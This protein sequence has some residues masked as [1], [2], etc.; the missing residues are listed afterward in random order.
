M[1]SPVITIAYQLSRHFVY[2]RENIAFTLRPAGPPATTKA[3]VQLKIHNFYGEVHG[4]RQDTAALISLSGRQ[5][6]SCRIW[7]YETVCVVDIVSS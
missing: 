6:A 2:V 5:V 3:A 4:L 7:F 1:W